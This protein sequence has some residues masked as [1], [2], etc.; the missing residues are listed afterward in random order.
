MPDENILATIEPETREETFLQDIADG[1]RT[2]TPAV[3]KE[4]FLRR[5]SAKPGVP[6]IAES[7]EGKV[8][9]VESGEAVWGESSSLPEITAQDEGKVLTVESGEAAWGEGGGGGGVVHVGATVDP[10]I[11]IAPDGTTTASSFRTENGF[12]A[13][14]ATEDEQGTVVWNGNV[15]IQYQDSVSDSLVVVGEI[16][17]GDARSLF[18]I[19]DYYIDSRTFYPAEDVAPTGTY[20]LTFANPISGSHKDLYGTGNYVLPKNN[21]LKW[22][23]ISGPN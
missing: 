7:D 20:A 23:V 21:A 19:S 2:L 17:D 9:T 6:S 13:V 1:T 14:V 5:I 22:V 15:A 12:Y 3:R 11:E 4:E 8:L 16:E 18:I 10:S